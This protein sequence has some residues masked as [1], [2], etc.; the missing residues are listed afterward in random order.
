MHRIYIIESIPKL[1]QD[2]EKALCREHQVL[3]CS[4]PEQ[5]LN[6][7][8]DFAPDFMVMD[9]TMPGL[10]GLGLLS[11]LFTAGIRPKLVVSMHYVEDA[12]EKMLDGF[13]A[14]FLL[15]RPVKTDV[16]LNRISDVLLEMDGG[17]N[18]EKRKIANNLLLKLGFRMDLQGYRYVLAAVV[19]VADH[20][21]CLLSN[22]LYPEL[23]KMLG[24]NAKQVEHIIRSSTHKAWA[25]RDER[26]W[27]LYFTRNRYGHMGKISNG[28]FL[29]RIAFAVND[30]YSFS[31]QD[32]PKANNQ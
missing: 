23:A 31:Q 7:I 20:M 28:K 15:M 19:Y 25:N 17:E 2:L 21:D 10:D 3:V 30:F 11:I 4:D 18:P 22:E 29:K 24:G 8:K 5:A 26:I 14:S 27:E 9:M 12:V 16:L 1:R 6:Q 13:H 32:L